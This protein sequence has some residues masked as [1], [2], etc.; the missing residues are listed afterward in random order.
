VVTNS[1]GSFHGYKA[2]KG[3][4]VLK[5]FRKED[6]LH[7]PLVTLSLQSLVQPHPYTCRQPTLHC[8]AMAEETPTD[9]TK[10]GSLQVTGDLESG[11]NTN[12]QEPGFLTDVERIKHTGFL[13][14]AA[15]RKF[16][17]TMQTEYGVK[18]A[19]VAKVAF[20]R[21]TESNASCRKSGAF[22]TTEC[23]FKNSLDY[24]RNPLGPTGA[25]VSLAEMALNEEMETHIG[26]LWP[27]HLL[28]CPTKGGPEETEAIEPDRKPD[29]ASGQG[30]GVEGTP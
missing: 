17:L 21:L 7:G 20:A 1:L 14:L 2:D 24:Y 27:D 12:T 5:G 29:Q 6:S 19:N 4:L 22:K 8:L 28:R 23:A 18:S 25:S 16:F 26:F 3:R 30:V 13:S 10:A 15:N 11:T 9:T